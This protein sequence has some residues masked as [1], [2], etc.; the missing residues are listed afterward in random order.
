MRPELKLQIL[1]LV[2]S[3]PFSMRETLGRLDVT[4]STYYRW[5]NRF[6]RHGLS[7]L[8][9]RSP[10]TGR[11]WNALL[12]EEREKIFK[13]ADEE[14]EWSPREVACH[15]TD[16]HGFSVSEATVYRIL[17]RAGLVKPREVKTFPAGPEYTVKT[18]RRNQMWQTDATYLLVKNWGW[19]YLI[20][21]LDDFSRRILA[22]RLQ[23][24]QN[25]DAFSEVVE[26]ACEAAGLEHVPQ[27]R[28]PLLLSDNGSAL[29]SQP[30]GDYLETKGLGHIFASPYHPQ[31]NG[32]SERYHRSCKERV[33]LVVW[34]TPGE[35]EHAIAQFIAYYN[36]ERYHEA[37]GNVT[38][39]D[40][41]FGRKESILV[42]RAQLKK[43]TFVKRKEHNAHRPWPQSVAAPG[44]ITQG[45]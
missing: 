6:R 4:V 38:P 42:R 35:L 3:S 25:A 16:H 23:S 14:P 32:K 13:V 5:R 17:K 12:P 45:G 9:D 21:I 40:V 39:D 1:R 2:E 43:E 30:F 24:F 44:S 18:K 29:I 28:R 20:S 11:V 22:W 26:L 15:I 19:Y 36:S 37:L 31:T 7:G 8:R 33:N 10:S 34:E 27:T 41:Y